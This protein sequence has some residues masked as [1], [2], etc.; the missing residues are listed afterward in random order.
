MEI[1]GGRCLKM[2]LRQ[3]EKYRTF[4]GTQKTAITISVIDTV[5][6]YEAM[7]GNSSIHLFRECLLSKYYVGGTKLA[8][9][10]Q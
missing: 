1:E 10:E 8:T 7:K 9:G 2:G 4:S 5:H 3:K 6:I